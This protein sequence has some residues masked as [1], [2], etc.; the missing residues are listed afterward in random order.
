MHNIIYKG[1][2]RYSLYLKQLKIKQRKIMKIK[3]YNWFLLWDM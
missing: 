1:K 2:Q 3:F